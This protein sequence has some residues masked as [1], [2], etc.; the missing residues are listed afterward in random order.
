[1]A[2]PYA[3]TAS[4]ADQPEVA[5]TEDFATDPVAAGRFNIRPVESVDRFTYDSGNAR[6]TAHY[7]TYQPTAWYMKPL[8]RSLRQYDSFEFSVTFRIHGDT[9]FPGGFGEITWGLVNSRTT[10]LDRVGCS[11]PPQQHAF[12]CLTFDFF[13][14]A[15]FPTMSPTIIKS[16]ELLGDMNYDGQVDG[17]DIEPFM[18]AL[19][20]GNPTARA[21]ARGDFNRNKIL[22]WDDV[23]PFAGKLMQPNDAM[24]FWGSMDFSSGEETLIAG[25]DDWIFPEHL[26]T[27]RVAYDGIDRVATLTISGDEGPLMINMVGTGGYGGPDGDPTTIQ[28]HASVGRGFNVDSFVLA[29]W[30]DTCFSGQVAADIDFLGIEFSASP[31]PL[32][33]LNQDGLVDARDIDSLLQALLSPESPQ[34]E[35]IARG[36]FNENGVLDLVDVEL[37]VSR[38]IQP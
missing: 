28:T 18:Q 11:D 20:S 32:G 25:G 34:P 7:D 3:G 14:N 10:G 27:A 22:D 9:F 17:R 33:D 21:I 5:W 12:D 36:D 30:N 23:P 29:A 35:V 1:M 4:F 26:Y 31:V 16:D 38:L 37:F 6:L 15:D 8:G 24:A 13:P 19:L 2:C